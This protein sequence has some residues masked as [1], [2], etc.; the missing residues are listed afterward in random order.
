MGTRIDRE[1]PRRSY[2]D[3]GTRALVLGWYKAGDNALAISS[4]IL[5][6]SPPNPARKPVYA[7][8][9]P[10]L[11]RTLADTLCSVVFLFGKASERTRIYFKSGWRELV[12]ETERMRTAYGA[13][14]AWT[15][16]FRQ[17]DE[18]IAGL[19]V[20]AGITAN[21]AANLHAIPRWPTP[22]RMIRNSDPAIDRKNYLQY[23]YDW[24][25]KR[26]SQQAH[27]A[28]IGI[29]PTPLLLPALETEQSIRVLEIART[30]HV[31]TSLTLMLAIITELELQLKVGLTDRAKFI[32]AILG[33]WDEDPKDFYTRFYE[34]ILGTATAAKI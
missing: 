19:K 22:G 10:P 5:A 31:M 23:I 9:V 2:P 21:E 34:P 8:G 12:E 13:D 4:F 15:E 25:Y 28:W 29:A 17:R 30:E 26:L 3:P 1:W 6:D 11:I 24:Y 18:A 16:F 32:W 20:R 27:L 33:S 14:V 7:L